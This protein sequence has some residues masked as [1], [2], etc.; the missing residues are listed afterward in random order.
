MIRLFTMVKDECD[1]IRE[2]IVYHGYVF[3]FENLFI[4]DNNSTD[5]TFEIMQEFLEKGIHISREDDYKKKGIYMKKLIEENC[6]TGDIAYPLDIDEFIVY[7]ERGTRDISC[8]KEKINEY[9][10]NLPNIGEVYKANYLCSVIT[11][12]GG[13]KN[14]PRDNKWSIYLDYGFSAKGFFKVGS[15]HGS[16]DHGNHY[17]GH[18]YFVTNICLVHFHCR[19]LEQIKKKILNNVI[20]LGYPNNIDELRNLLKSNPSIGGNHHINNLISIIEGT[21]KLNI[22]EYNDTFI[23]LE[24]LNNFIK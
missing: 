20:G 24:N 17:G 4:I 16:I 13:Y 15:Y 1:I 9:I 23:S 7:H 6:S 11:D 21:Y 14:A 3:G 2:W 12:E 19:N 22:S 5:G 8:D 18:N 10:L